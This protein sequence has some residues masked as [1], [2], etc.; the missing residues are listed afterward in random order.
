MLVEVGVGLFNRKFQMKADI[1]T[2]PLLVALSCGIKISTVC[3]FISSQNMRDGQTDGQNY[4][5]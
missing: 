5:H 4:D 1:A 3:S 2:Q